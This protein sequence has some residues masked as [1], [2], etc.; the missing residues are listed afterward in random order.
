MSA[1]HIRP[2][3]PGAWELKYDVGRDPIT[4]KRRIKYKT[5]RG[6][7]SDAQR[8]LRGHA[9]QLRLAMTP[10]PFARLGL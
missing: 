9:Q 3:G 5:A 10:F 1:G 2:R 8:E 7:K 4:G 6:K